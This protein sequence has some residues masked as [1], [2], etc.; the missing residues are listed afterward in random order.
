MR[1]LQPKIGVTHLKIQA[2]KRIKIRNICAYKFWSPCS[3]SNFGSRA[4]RKAL[5]PSQQI[6]RGVQGQALWSS[7]EVDLYGICPINLA[8]WSSV[9]LGSLRNTLQILS[10]HPFD[11][12]LLNELLMNISSRNNPDQNFNQLELFNL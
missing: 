11:K 6:Q 12:T 2:L 8:Q 1:Q 5:S 10:V 9:Y 3:C 7:T 4:S